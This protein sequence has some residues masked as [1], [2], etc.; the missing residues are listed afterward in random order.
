MIASAIVNLSVTSCSMGSIGVCPSTIGNRK[1]WT[2]WATVTYIPMSAAPPRRVEDLI[3]VAPPRAGRSGRAVFPGPATFD[4]Q[5]PARRPVV[6]FAG[7]RRVAMPHR[8]APGHHVAAR[9]AGARL[10]HAAIA[11]YGQ[12][13]GKRFDDIPRGKAD[14]D[15]AVAD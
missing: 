13:H 14:R 15:R 5:G 10:E 7:R 8:S 6:G 4:R 2:A 1:C 12:R 3:P 9:V 11:R